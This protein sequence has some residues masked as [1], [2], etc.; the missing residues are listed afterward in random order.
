MLFDVKPAAG[1]DAE[2]AEQQIGEL[3]QRGITPR[4]VGA[5]RGYCARDFI[6]GLR[7]HGAVPH[8]AP[9]NDRRL[10]QVKVRLQAYQLSPKSRR[11][12]EEIFGWAKTTGCFRNSRYMHSRRRSV[13]RCHLQSGSDGPPLPRSAETGAGV[14]PAGPPHGCTHD[15]AFCRPSRSFHFDPV[16]V[17]GFETPGFFDG[18]LEFKERA[19][20]IAMEWRQ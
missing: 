7:D 17:I 15:C 14:T 18:L 11:N 8:P 9:M 5:G 3:L 2:V 16:S 6:K 1:S 10:H 13:C 12:I 19:I 4:T 20:L